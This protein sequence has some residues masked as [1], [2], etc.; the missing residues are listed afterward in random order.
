MEKYSKE[1]IEELVKT[2]KSKTEI[3]KKLGLNYSGGNYNTLTKYLEL[4][5]ID[6]SKLNGRN[7]SYG[8][9][10]KIDLS[11]ILVEK[12]TYSNSNHLKYRLYK[13]GIKERKCELCGQG[14]IWNNMEI[15]LILDH[16]NGKHNDNRL[17]NLRIVCPNCNAGLETHC[18]GSK[19]KNKKYTRFNLMEAVKSSKNYNDIKDKLGLVRSVSN[20]TI[21]KILIRYNIDFKCE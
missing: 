8:I 15:S 21:K 16:I 12:S 5:E 17:E 19:F 7:N 13:E 1:R 2:S 18:R 11:E 9:I 20:Q 4:Y 6:D 14:E 10:K 3:L